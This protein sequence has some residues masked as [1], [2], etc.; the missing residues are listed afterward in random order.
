[1]DGGQVAVHVRTEETREGNWVLVALLGN[2]SEVESGEFGDWLAAHNKRY[3]FK[4][5]EEGDAPITRLETEGA[6]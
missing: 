3:G 2:P 6:A 5:C 4:V 1:M